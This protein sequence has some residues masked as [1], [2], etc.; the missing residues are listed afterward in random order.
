MGSFRNILSLYRSAC[1]YGDPNSDTDEAAMGLRIASDG[2]FQRI[3]V[4]TLSEADSF[5]RQL[6]SVRQL[7]GFAIPS[8]IFKSSKCASG[9]LSQ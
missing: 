4:F 9:L 2:A 7:P 1:H 3:L 5:F 6:L 8:G